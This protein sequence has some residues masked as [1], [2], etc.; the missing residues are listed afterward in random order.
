[1][2]GGKGSRPRPFS[3]PHEEYSKR[4]DNIFKKDMDLTD[5]EDSLNED[6]EF[7]R[8]KHRNTSSKKK[9]K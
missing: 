6:E 7:E 2:V 4:W 5:Y 9:D 8:I 1:M 3:V